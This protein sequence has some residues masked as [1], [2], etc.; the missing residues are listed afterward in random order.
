MSIAKTRK[1]NELSIISTASEGEGLGLE[2]LINANIMLII[3]L[4]P[5]FTITIT[6][7][8]MANSNTCT[9]F[10]SETLELYCY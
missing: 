4:T 8:K 9:W 2:F 1:K 3:I 10:L 7:D 6:Q 5:A